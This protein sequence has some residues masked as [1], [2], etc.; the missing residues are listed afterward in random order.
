MVTS[1]QIRLE[2]DRV[3]HAAEQ[4]LRAERRLGALLA[5]AQFRRGGRPG[6]LPSR[7]GR[8]FLTLAEVGVARHRSS[9]YQRLAKIDDR[10]FE[11][12]LADARTAGVPA[13][14]A[15]ALRAARPTGRRISRGQTRAEVTTRN[16]VAFQRH[17]RTALRLAPG[18]GVTEQA[19]ALR[20]C[21]R[22]AQQLERLIKTDSLGRRVGHGS[23]EASR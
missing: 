5:R 18:F 16:S 7:N 8:V 1:T 19:Q 2:R 22:F 15:G 4:M 13:S 10:R 20:S 12:Y 21:E 3:L 23:Q 9:K 17:L 6:S 14:L 11:S